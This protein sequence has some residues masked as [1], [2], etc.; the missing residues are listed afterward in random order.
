[1]KPAVTGFD[2]ALM[3]VCLAKL[4]LEPPALE[5]QVGALECVFNFNGGRGG[6]WCLICFHNNV[7]ET[8]L[9]TIPQQH[10]TEGT[11][12]EDDNGCLDKGGRVLWFERVHGVVT[13]FVLKLWVCQQGRFKKFPVCPASV[14]SVVK[15]L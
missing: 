13:D 10:G 4:E 7:C 3:G 12:H 14:L 2:A 8:G 15:V 11:G 5:I 1:M 6:C 9:M